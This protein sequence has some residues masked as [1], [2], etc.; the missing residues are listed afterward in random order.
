MIEHD[1]GGYIALFPRSPYIPLRSWRATARNLESSTDPVAIERRGHGT[2]HWSELD[3]AFGDWSDS[4]AGRRRRAGARRRRDCPAPWRVAAGHR[5]DPD[6]FRHV[7]AGACH[8]H[9]CSAQ[10]GSGHRRWQCRRLQH[11]ERA[12]DPSDRR[13]S[14]PD[15]LRSTR[16]SPGRTGSDP[17][18]VDLRGIGYERPCRALDGRRPS[19]SC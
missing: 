15:R 1:A 9:R 12:P 13:P 7:G 18:G 16:P 19:C 5:R 10:G 14:S 4:D 11:R 6:R 17:V 2:S 8:L 3:L